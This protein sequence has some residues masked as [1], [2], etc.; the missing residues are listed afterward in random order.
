MPTIAGAKMSPACRR[1][2]PHA[3][4]WIRFPRRMAQEAGKKG[5]NRGF[6]PIANRGP[7]LGAFFA[8]AVFSAQK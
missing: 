8:Q 6:W 4:A 7:S 3:H 5:V 1:S 2:S